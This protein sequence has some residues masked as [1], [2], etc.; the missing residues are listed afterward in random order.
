[1]TGTTYFP[2]PPSSV[3][4]HPPA[5]LAERVIGARLVGAWVQLGSGAEGA[6]L[7]S[8]CFCAGELVLAK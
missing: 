7:P 1:M 5:S 3:L 6:P 2:L 4:V 8:R